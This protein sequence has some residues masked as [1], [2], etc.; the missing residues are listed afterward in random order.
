MASL[1]QTAYYSRQGIKYGSIALVIL[2]ILRAAFISFQAYWKKVHPPPPPPPTVAF[3]KLPKLNFP[4][5]ENLPELTFK[6]ETISGSLP[7]QPTQT[8]VF[9]I[10]QPSTNLLAWD[11]TKAWARQLGFMKEPEATDKFVYR[12]TSETQPP[13]TLEVNVLT[14]NFHFF[15]DWKNDM[16]VFSL[17]NPPQKEKA[18]VDVKAFFQG[19]EAL[20]EDL[21]QGP[22]EVIFLKYKDGE[23]K[24]ALFFSEAN[25]AKVNL[26][27]T[28]IN[29]LKVLPAD[30]K[31]ANVSLLLGPDGSRNRAIMEVNYIHAPVSLEN[32]ATYPLKDIDSAWKELGEGKGF[33]ANLGNNPQGRATIRDAYLAYYDSREPQNFLQPVFVF[34]GDNGFFAYVPAVTDNWREQESAK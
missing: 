5:R 11:N 30:P 6:M 12:F 29:S 31:D 16:E 26:F 15:Y 1:T 28:D 17:G 21:A 13:V 25:F 33:I 19:A 23:L 2:L 20:T 4:V 10:P 7:K 24:E 27:R 32:S 34:E 3:G 14:R 9:F 18:I 22:A 8:K